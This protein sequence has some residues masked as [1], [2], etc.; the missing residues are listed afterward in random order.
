[1]SQEVAIL[2]ELYLLVH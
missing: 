1:M 2:Q